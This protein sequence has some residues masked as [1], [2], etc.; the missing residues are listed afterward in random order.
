[1]LDD[2]FCR[3]QEPDPYE[4]GTHPKMFTSLILVWKPEVPLR[5]RR[6]LYCRL[7][8]PGPYEHGTLRKMFTSL[9]WKPEKG[10]TY[11]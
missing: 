11:C 6:D 2:L 8:E 3:L 10:R 9:I 7:Q 5:A 4:H 1:M